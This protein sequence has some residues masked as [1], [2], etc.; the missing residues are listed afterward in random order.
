MVSHQ[1]IGVSLRQAFDIHRREVISLVGGGGKTTLM[2]AL[3]HELETAGENVIS[4]TTTR[5]LEPSTSE[6][7]LIL[8]RDENNLLSRV[9]DELKHHRHITLAA[10]KT[11]DGK[12]KGIRP[13]MVDRLAE[14][15]TVPYIIV[16]ADGAARKPLKAP[17]ATEPVIPESTSLVIAVVGMDALGSRLTEEN[18]F[19]AEIVSR[20]TGLPLGGTV[21]AETIATLMTH[22]QGIIKGSPAHAR[23][24]PLINKIDIIKDL[25]PVEDIAGK[26]LGKGHPQI[27]RVVWGHVGVGS[28]TSEGWGLGG[29]E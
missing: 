4:T 14:V 9:M 16:E 19:R 5:I 15:K 29:R 13:E 23:I 20:L 25:S 2:F 21:S 12:L 24:V 6:T 1:K 10:F 7:F 26:I 8:E 17:N 22:P 18:V 3:A 28:F 27:K 11:P